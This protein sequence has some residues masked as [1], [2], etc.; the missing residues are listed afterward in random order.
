VLIEVKPLHEL[1]GEINQA[2]FRAARRF[3]HVQG[4]GLL[5][6]DGSRTAQRVW[7]RQVDPA[8]TDLLVSQMAEAGH[9]SWSR[10]QTLRGSRPFTHFDLAAVALAQ[11]WASRRGPFRI[12]QLA[13]ADRD[14]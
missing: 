8:V 1:I 6:T 3:C 12:C 2:K 11:G 10:L 4:W 13:P 7:A 9:L 14:A 5:V